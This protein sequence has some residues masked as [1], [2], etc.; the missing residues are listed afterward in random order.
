VLFADIPGFTAIASKLDA[1]DVHDMLNALWT[2]LD[3]IIKAHGGM[4]DKH[5]G[6]GLMA[7][8]GAKTGREEDPEH[9]VRAALE[10]QA[11]IRQFKPAREMA[12]VQ[13]RVGIH[14][15][16]VVLGQMG[17]T[18]EFTATG[19]AV[20]IASHF[21]REAPPGGILISHETY[22]QVC[23]LF[24]VEVMPALTLKGK[25][26]TLQAYRVLHAKLHPVSLRNRGI[27]GIDWQ[28]VGRKKELGRLQNVF[29]SV[30]QEGRARV[31]TLLGEPGIGKSSLVREFQNW[32]ELLPDN[33]RLL[34]ARAT[35]E[36]A[37]VPF[38]PIRDLFW[39]RFQIL[40]NDPAR[41]R[42]RN[43]RRNV[44]V[45]QRVGARQEQRQI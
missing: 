36:T 39:S 13:M 32:V 27:Q 19:D 38:A 20:N 3:A 44:R 35:P 12:P 45:H 16:M 30:L 33:V 37:T 24:D 17:S 6:D 14:T 5:M 29:R 11:C 23:G 7:L 40:E 15:G 22:Q 26:E 2:K 25:A 31:F 4:I 10:L 34:I 9:A 28:M 21:E 41:S 18:R 43:L 42:E 1:E 8:F